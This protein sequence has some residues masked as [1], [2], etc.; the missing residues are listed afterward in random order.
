MPW[1]ESGGRFT[2]MASEWSADS[3]GHGKADFAKG[4]LGITG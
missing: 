3:G 1:R 4:K 2:S